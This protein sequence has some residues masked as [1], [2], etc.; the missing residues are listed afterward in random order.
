MTESGRDRGAC[1][2]KDEK[3][4]TSVGLPVGS[5]R[6]VP[7]AVFNSANG[8]KRIQAR[9]LVTQTGQRGI[10]GADEPL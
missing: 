1:E 5:A 9:D 6:R 10:L 7:T 3:Q 4:R 2:E 8:R